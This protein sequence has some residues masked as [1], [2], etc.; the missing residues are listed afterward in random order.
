[1]V[2]EG[3]IRDKHAKPIIRDVTN[4]INKLRLKKPKYRSIPFGN[5]LMNSPLYYIFGEKT[6]KKLLKSHAKTRHVVASQ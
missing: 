4:N 1:L 3:E 5:L 2:E 6:C